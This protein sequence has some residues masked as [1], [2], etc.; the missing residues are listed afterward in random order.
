MEPARVTVARQSPADVRQRQMVV[1]IDGRPW[2]TLM[3]GQSVT[4]EL[5]PGPHRLRVHNTLVWKTA[6]LVLA[7]GE[8]A[9]F[10]IV[11]RA[12]WGTYWLLAMLGSGPL[13]VTLIREESGD[14]PAK[15]TVPLG[16]QSR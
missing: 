10:T 15:G 13:F 11:N 2:A 7:P 3:Y 1:S 14:S 9:R 6:D 5:P 12:G 16:G 8:H 4:R